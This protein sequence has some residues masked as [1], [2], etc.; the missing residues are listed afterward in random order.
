MNADQ[1]HTIRLPTG[2]AARLKAATGQPLSRLVRFICMELLRKYEAEQAGNAKDKVRADV[3]DA[4]LS[5]DI[6][7]EP[8]RDD[9]NASGAE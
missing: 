7:Q 9:P 4:V 5:V 8:N 1:T 3:R 6:E 2:T